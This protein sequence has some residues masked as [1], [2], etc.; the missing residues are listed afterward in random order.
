MSSKINA[1]SRFKCH[2]FFTAS[3]GRVPRLSVKRKAEVLRAFFAA[4]VLKFGFLDTRVARGTRLA[5][6]SSLAYPLTTQLINF[7]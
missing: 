6:F 2:V 7:N 5:Q 4:H 1:E 3:I